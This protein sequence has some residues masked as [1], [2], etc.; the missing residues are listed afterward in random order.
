MSVD[1]YSYDD[2]TKEMAKARIQRVREAALQAAA[3]SFAHD[4]SAF[5]GNSSQQRAKTVV[6]TAQVFEHYILTGKNLLA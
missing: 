5:H 6:T 3:E 1:T 2:R 4:S